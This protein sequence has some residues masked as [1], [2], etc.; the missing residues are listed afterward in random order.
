[1]VSPLGFGSL[2]NTSSC[3]IS[4]GG[5]HLNKCSTESFPIRLTLTLDAVMPRA[6]S[7]LIRTDVC[8]IYENVCNLVMP[9]PFQHALRR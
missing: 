4:Q 5:L 6:T 9:A 8:Q 2:I 7:F 1:M 3:P